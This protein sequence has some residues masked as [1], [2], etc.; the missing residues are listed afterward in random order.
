[1]SVS[2][3]DF[4]LYVLFCYVDFLLSANV[5]CIFLAST[6]ICFLNGIF[7]FLFS[8]TLS[9]AILVDVL[10]VTRHEAGKLLSQHATVERVVEHWFVH[11]KADEE[12]DEDEKKDEGEKEKEMEKE[13][14]QEEV[15]DEKENDGMQNFCPLV[16]FELV[17]LCL[18]VCFV[19][20]LVGLFWF[21]CFVCF[22]LSACF[23]FFCFI[24]CVFVCFF[25]FCFAFFVFVLFF[26]FLLGVPGVHCK[27]FISFLSYVLFLRTPPYKSGKDGRTAALCEFLQREDVFEDFLQASDFQKNHCLR[28]SQKAVVRT[29]CPRK[30][31]GRQGSFAERRQP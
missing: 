9:P 25:C 11:H 21:I 14:A 26:F 22:V 5:A 1:M 12:E 30:H 19:L 28:R 6:C 7:F 3:F 13:K 8:H 18:L 17:F 23:V 27:V 16:F 2:N 10:E 24:L 29:S 31:E 15:E 4:Y 20:V